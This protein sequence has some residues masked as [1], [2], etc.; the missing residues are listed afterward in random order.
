MGVGRR[1]I[2]LARANLNALLDRAASSEL[3]GMSEAQLQDELDRRKR[4]REA[5]EEESK[6]RLAAEAAAQARAKHRQTAPKPKAAPKPADPYRVL[7]VSRTA[8][9]EEVKKAYRNLMREHHPDKHAGD[10]AAQKRASAMTIEI[11]SAYTIIKDAR[12]K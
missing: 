2:D 3:E 7:G 10:A 6:K 8:S 1:L 5:Q 4:E 9:L 11:T 12:K